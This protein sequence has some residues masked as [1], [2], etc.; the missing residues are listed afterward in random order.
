MSRSATRRGFALVEIVLAVLVFEVIVVASHRALHATRVLISESVQREHA[1]ME[2]EALLD[3][4]EWFGGAGSG[5]RIGP[6]G[7]LEWVG[8][9]G[10]GGPTMVTVD[11]FGPQ[12]SAP[13]AQFVTFVP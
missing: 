6:W 5:I 7:R 3:S 13:Y 12:G 9:G 10:A 4:L 11:L 8:A 2:A 1:L